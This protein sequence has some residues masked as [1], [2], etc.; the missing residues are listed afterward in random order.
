MN[1]RIF[2]SLWGMTEGATWDDKL[3]LVKAAGYDGVEFAPPADVAPDAWRAMCARHGL[4]YIAAVYSLTPNEFEASLARAAGYGPILVNAQTGRDRY[5][6]D[7]GC[8]YFEHALRAEQRIGVH[9]AHETHRHRLLFTP[10][11]TAAYLDKFPELKITADFSHWVLVCESRL[12][13]VDD[14][15]EKASARALH[16]HARVGYE[17]GPQA[18]DPRAPEFAEYVALFEGWWERIA[19]MA[20]RSGAARLTMTP[21]YG[22]PRYQ[23]TLPYTGQP[24]ANVWDVCLWGAER[25]RRLAR[26]AS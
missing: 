15:L 26:A 25:L 2:K 21:E 8:R 12:A 5:A 4:E 6:F 17:E 16:I 23:Q 20:A 14:L 24:V 1:V 3:R 18:P 10:W 22:P 9:V 13:D 11:T 7:E 19:R